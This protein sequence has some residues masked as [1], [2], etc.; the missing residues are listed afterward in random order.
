MART[1]E[2]SFGRLPLREQSIKAA[3]A[4]R[5]LGNANSAPSTARES[6]SKNEPLPEAQTSNKKPIPKLKLKNTH[7]GLSEEG[8]SEV[9]KPNTTAS[10]PQQEL[11]ESIRRR[12]SRPRKKVTFEVDSALEMSES[13]DPKT[14]SARSS[15]STAKTQSVKSAAMDLDGD[16]FRVQQPT[17]AVQVKIQVPRDAAT[18]GSGDEN[19]DEHSPLDDLNMLDQQIEAKKKKNA[20]ANRP[21][22][23]EGKQPL[24][25]AAPADKDV[26]MIDDDEDEEA[27]DIDEGEV[28]YDDVRASEHDLSPS[29]TEDQTREI[30]TLSSDDEGARGTDPKKNDDNGEY[31]LDETPWKTQTFTREVREVWELS[32]C[33]VLK[34]AQHG[35]WEMTEFFQLKKD[36]EMLRYLKDFPLSEW[37]IPQK[38]ASEA[39]AALHERTRWRSVGVKIYAEQQAR[40]AQ[41]SM[42]SMHMQMQSP[43]SM[44]GNMHPQAYQHPG[45]NGHPASRPG[46]IN[47]QGMP[48]RHPQSPMNGMAPPPP[49]QVLRSQINQMPMNVTPGRGPQPMGPPPPPFGHSQHVGGPYGMP[50]G[51]QYYQSPH[52]M[53]HQHQHTHQQMQMQPNQMGPPQPMP[54]SYGHNQARPPVSL[55][56]PKPKKATPQPATTPPPAPVPPYSRC[57]RPGKSEPRYGGATKTGKRGARKQAEAEEFPWH[58][59]LDFVKERDD[60]TWDESKYDKTIMEQMSIVRRLNVPVIIAIDDELAEKQKL[61][62]NKKKAAGSGR[63]PSPKDETPS[64]DVEMEE[65]GDKGSK[66]KNENIGGDPYYSG[67]FSFATEED[68]KKAFDTNPKYKTPDDIITAVEDGDFDAELTKDLRH[69]WNPGKKGTTQ[70][71]VQASFRI[72]DTIITRQMYMI[73]KILTKRAAECIIDFSP[74]ILWR[75]VLLRIVSEAGMGNKDVRDRF[76]YNGCYADKATITKRIAAALGQKQAIAKRGK[77]DG[78]PPS[79]K[80][81][82]RG[83]QASNSERYQDGEEEWHDNNKMDF[84][85]YIRFF[86]KRPGG[87]RQRVGEKRKQSVGTEEAV[88]D[89]PQEG[90]S[91]RAKT[92]P[93]SMSPAARSDGSGESSDE[94]ESE[95]EKKVEEEAEEEDEED[96]QDD[97]DAVSVQSDG[98]LDAIPDDD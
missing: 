37:I 40:E 65:P 42:H 83:P 52:Q 21:W 32:Y 53:P 14:S 73:T 55:R 72:Y 87:R 45:M 88:T 7:K 36:Q 75:E 94:E 19:D 68:A 35:S 47:Q 39:Y 29:D 1:K 98:V 12:S 38:Q 11:G 62:R 76:C 34:H 84:D 61:S 90:S 59:A 49:G 48:Y 78:E 58:R 97:G 57:E 31:D 10:T 18:K 51:G 96:D 92:E 44:N 70:E 20:G 85:N 79:S 28:D 43:M 93:T 15:L 22:G 50:N 54:P 81:K 6:A 71:L 69:C 91:K 64:G 95:A 9:D 17:D 16:T 66:R 24:R 80:G 3:A 60:A 13:A 27:E 26:V 89:D 86:G 82:K 46:S 30:I 2:P 41:Q 23:R 25:N 56:A 8:P 67:N 74:D 77:Q 63:V 33:N 5:L 4:R